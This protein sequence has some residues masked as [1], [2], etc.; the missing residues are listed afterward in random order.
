MRASARLLVGE[1]HG[2]ELRLSQYDLSERSACVTLYLILS[3]GS[4]SCLLWFIQAGTSGG[5]GKHERQPTQAQA[6]WH[7]VQNHVVYELSLCYALSC[8]RG[9]PLMGNS[10]YTP[11][12]LT[13]QI[14]CRGLLH[15]ETLGYTDHTETALPLDRVDLCYSLHCH[16]HQGSLPQLP[17]TDQSR[18]VF[19]S[20]C[21]CNSS[22]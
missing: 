15:Q 9:S 6:V 14:L 10:K 22:L 1:P 17:V 18:I 4:L 12:T 8:Q 13:S 21:V 3:A 20:T 5:V 7:S 16:L 2:L 11:Y 19:C